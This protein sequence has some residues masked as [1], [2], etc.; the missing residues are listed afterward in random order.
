MKVDSASQLFTLPWDQTL[1]GYATA[2]DM[3]SM[4]SCGMLSSNMMFLQVVCYTIT[5]TI[6]VMIDLNKH[7]LAVI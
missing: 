1:V 2:C 7:S 6:S 5:F 4:L 3:I